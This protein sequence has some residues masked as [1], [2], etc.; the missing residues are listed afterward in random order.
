MQKKRRRERTNGSTWRLLIL[1]TSSRSSEA[2]CWTLLRRQLWK[3]GRP[4]QK[5]IEPRK[6]PKTYCLTL[7]TSYQ[8]AP[9]TNPVFRARKSTCAGYPPKRQPLQK[10]KEGKRDIRED[11]TPNTGASPYEKD[12][13]SKIR[14]LH[15]IDARR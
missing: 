9:V 8:S 7:D 14:S 15:A 12:F 2:C 3:Q 10:E 4:D 5:T 13:D 6:R 11:E 1:A